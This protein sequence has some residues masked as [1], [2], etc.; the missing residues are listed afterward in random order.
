MLSFASLGSG[1]EGNC[2]LIKSNEAIIMIDCGFNYKETTK[3]LAR[4]DLTFSDINHYFITHEHEDHIKAAPM[5]YKNEN[6]LISSTYGTAKRLG[7]EN[8]F[9]LLNYDQIV[10]I[11]DI[12]VKVIPVP[13]DAMEPCHYTFES[14]NIKVGIITDFGSIT[15]KIIEEYSNLDLLVIETNHDL[16][17]LEKSN[18]PINLKNRISGPY[19]HTNN[20]LTKALFEKLNKSRLKKVIFCHLSKNNNTQEQVRKEFE[21]YF[22]KYQCDF[23]EQDNVFDWV[24]IKN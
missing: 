4:L 5:I 21:P 9:S 8:N 7:M 16:E 19:G 15:E 20:Q 3:R 23:I 6:M 11:N 12:K 13:H 2:F 18:Y 22:K 14:N 10:D 1:S 17:M 24:T